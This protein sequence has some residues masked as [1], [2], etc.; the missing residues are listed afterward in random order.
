MD[1]L[2]IKGDESV[3]CVA[4][5]MCELSDC[6]VVYEDVTMVAMYHMYQV[7]GTMMAKLT[8]PYI[9]GI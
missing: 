9:L 5:V 4:L 7:G 2:F 8:V 3:A 1:L 6:G